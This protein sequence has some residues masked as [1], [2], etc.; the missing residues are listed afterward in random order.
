MSLSVDEVYQLAKN[1]HD[2][3]LL[4]KRLDDGNANLLITMASDVLDLIDDTRFT[5]EESE[6]IDKI[7]EELSNE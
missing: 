6:D 2:A 5:K 4:M 7:V 3:S 1:L